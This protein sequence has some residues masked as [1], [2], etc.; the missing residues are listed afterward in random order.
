MNRPRTDHE[1]CLH[2]AIERVESHGGEMRKGTDAK[3]TDRILKNIQSMVL[4]SGWGNPLTLDME[5][6][7]LHSE[8]R[9]PE[10]FG[11]G[12]CADACS[13]DERGYHLNALLRRPF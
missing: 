4:V 12:S 7:P 2:P 10:G 8:G 11:G 9:F 1:E 13:F 3:G 6:A 5:G